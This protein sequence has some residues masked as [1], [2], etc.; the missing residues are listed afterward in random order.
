MADEKQLELES[1]ASIRVVDDGDGS[2][3]YC[4]RRCSHFTLGHC[5]LFERAL[6]R[7]DTDQWV[8]CADCRDAPVSQDLRD[9]YPALSR[10]TSGA[11]MQDKVRS[12]HTAKMRKAA[13]CD[14][15]KRDEP[16]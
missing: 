5:S 7:D 10:R 3:R 14:D 9:K 15:K 8:R 1:G 13:G 11:T 2:Y 4:S 12:Q 16:L 6:F